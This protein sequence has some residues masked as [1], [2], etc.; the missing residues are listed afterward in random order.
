MWFYKDQP[1][2]DVPEG[3]VAFVYLIT[4]METGRA[5]VGK[6]RCFFKKTKIKTVKTK[7]GKA[8]KK[9]RS[10]VDSDWREYYGSSD[11][12]LQDVERCGRENF[13][14]E[15]LHLCPT[16]GWSSYLECREQCDRR[17]MENPDKFYN[18]WMSARIR[19]SH[20]PVKQRPTTA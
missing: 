16:L 1:F 19:R 13:R 14:R 18:T 9:L 11:D 4:N 10:V 17:V 6:K 8:K 12:L 7:T 3:I 20:V 5:Y 2:L 15:I